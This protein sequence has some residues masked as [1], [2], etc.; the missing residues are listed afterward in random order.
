MPSE[1]LAGA[2]KLP[3]APVTLLVVDDNPVDRQLAAGLAE[4][5]LGWQT[6]PAADGRD[7][8]ARLAD[9]APDLV[10]TDL[11]M[12]EMDGLELVEAVRERHPLVPVV[13][14]TAHGSEAL[15]LEALERG[16]AGYVPKDVLER[17]LVGTLE[18][19]LAAA[20]ASQRR[21]RLLECVERTES[22]YHLDNDR[23]L[24]PVL[25]MQLQESLVAM[26]LGDQTDRIRVGIALEEALTNALYH[27]N[28]EVSSD[29][30]RHDDQ[31][32]YQ[33][34]EE[35]RAQPPYRDRR[36]HVL[37]RLDREQAVFVVRDEG[38][39]FDPAALPDP[40]DPANLEKQSGRGVFLIRT[41]MDEVRYNAAGNE[42][43]L[44]K[45]RRRPRA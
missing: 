1:P 23:S 17:D 42:V 9:R 2:R 6:V 5:A 15:A 38:P 18:Q 36:I 34:A 33:L 39:G 13:L 25:V 21:L 35:R 26:K 3:A 30:R 4:K 44:V 43:T 37:A 7:A 8:L 40:R 41:F 22:L 16:A 20:R 31:S 19:V 45:R 32:F 27:G 29:L 14:M 24:L 10:L 12:P 28:L 11:L